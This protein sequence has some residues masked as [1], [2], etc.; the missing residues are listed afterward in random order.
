MKGFLFGLALT[1]IIGQIPKLLGVEKGTGN[2]FDQMFY[3]L[4]EIGHAN[5]S[6]V[7]LASSQHRG[8]GGP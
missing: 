4:N 1:I 8:H 2:F 5:S 7:V 3:V 6:T